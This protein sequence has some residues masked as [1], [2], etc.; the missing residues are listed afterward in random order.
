[1]AEHGHQRIA[2]SRLVMLPETGHMTMFERPDEVNA[3]IL[4]FVGKL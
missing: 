1:V 2:G 3:A 4:E